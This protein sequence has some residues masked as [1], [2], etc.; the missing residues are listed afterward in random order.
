MTVL[1]VILRFAKQTEVSQNK[2]L[3]RVANWT[4][5]DNNHLSYL[6]AKPQQSQI[7]SQISN[8]PIQKPKNPTQNLIKSYLQSNIKNHKIPQIFLQIYQIPAESIPKMTKNT[9]S[10][11]PTSP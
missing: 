4:R 7:Y 6:R 11:S 10:Q 9:K 2:R 8:L 5:N 3:P 1:F